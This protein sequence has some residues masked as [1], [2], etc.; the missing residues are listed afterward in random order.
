M[1]APWTLYGDSVQALRLIEVDVA[2]GYVPE[3]LDIVQVVPGRTLGGICVAHYGP[4]SVL[5]Y[6]ELI[7]VPAIVRF[8]SRR[9][10]WVSHIYVNDRESMHGGQAIW[11]LPKQLARF[12]RTVS[13]DGWSVDVSL[14]AQQLCSAV[15]EPGRARWPFVLRL[16]ML[17][18]RDADVLRTRNRITGRL[19]VGSARITVP[20]DSPFAGLF[21]G[22]ALAAMPMDRL[23]ATVQAPEPIGRY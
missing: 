11:G 17:T 8:R 10:L 15:V 21:G 13:E 2:R 6:D 3:A 18:M 20:V 4:G 1:T 7:I 12:E 23:R 14:P 22:D 5:E 9:G 16:P 19:H